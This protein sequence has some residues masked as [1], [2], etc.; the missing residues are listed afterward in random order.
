MMNFAEEGCDSHIHDRN[1]ADQRLDLAPLPPFLRVLLT[2]DGTITKSLAAYF[3]EP[4]RVAI[5][6]QGY[7]ALA[8]PAPA[9]H[10]QCG[11]T[12]LSRKVDLLGKDTNTLYASAESCLCSERLPEL[13]RESLE[14]GTVGIGE[15]LRDSGL[16]TYREILDMG[17]MKRGGIDY[18]WRRYRVVMSHDPIIQITEYFPLSS[19]RPS[20]D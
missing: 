13:I 7:V 20:S 3:L 1:K 14:A 15:L 8:E 2:T 17:A 19:Y 16:E 11:D 6:E 12:V 10:R 5:K 9:I 4:I 18:V